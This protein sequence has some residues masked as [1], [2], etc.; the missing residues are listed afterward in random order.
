[1]ND[2]RMYRL[3][4]ASTEMELRGVFPTTLSQY[5]IACGKPVI[6]DSDIF[7]LTG[8]GAAATLVELSALAQH[9]QL[10]EI[11]QVGIAGAYSQ[12]SLSIGDVVYVA[13]DCY[14]DLG[15][16]S[17]NGFLTLP[18]MDLGEIDT[19]RGSQSLFERF[20]FSVPATQ[21]LTV[22]CCSGTEL[23]IAMRKEKFP[24]D[25]ETMEGA[26][27]YHFA[28]RFTIPAIQIRG[29]SNYVSVRDTSIWNISQAITGLKELFTDVI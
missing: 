15:A 6:I 27:L 9:Y 29:I 4:C 14:G 5:S 25:V 2:L 16:E 13:S 10:T 26:A 28:A 24:C 11:I 20:N 8:I 12:S 7:A 23:T 21:G 19:Y 17:E 1:M 3:F 22:N 18:E